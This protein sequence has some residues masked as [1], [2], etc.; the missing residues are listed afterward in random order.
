MAF[1]AFIVWGAYTSAATL[2]G[3]PDAFVAAGAVSANVWLAALMLER[4]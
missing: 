4:R 2:L 3:W 1:A